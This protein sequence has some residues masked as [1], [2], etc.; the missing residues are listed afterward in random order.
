LMKAALLFIAFL[1]AFS[2]LPFAFRAA[3]CLFT[4]A[5]YNPH[6]NPLPSFYPKRSP[7]HE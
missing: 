7:L 4:F 1:F 3:V 5:F 6:R 2:P